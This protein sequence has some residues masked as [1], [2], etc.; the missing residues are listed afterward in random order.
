MRFLADECC[1]AAL[2]NDLRGDG[3]DVLYA[4]ESLRGATDDRLLARAFSEHRILLTEDKDFGELVYRLRRQA[5][6][7]VLLRFDVADRALKI[8]RL[9]YLLEQEG[10]RLAGAFVVLEAG[11]VR[12]RPLI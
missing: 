6:G 12:I 3:H 9:R 7:I 5:H 11:K 1:D 2:V 8:A 4:V 10:E